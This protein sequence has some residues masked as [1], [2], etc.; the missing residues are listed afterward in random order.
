MKHLS[1]FVKVGARRLKVSKGE[2]VLVFRNP[3]GQIVIFC[4]NKDT[5]D[6]NLV[7]SCQGSVINLKLA[8]KTFNTILI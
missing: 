5:K 1:H 2:N 3:D 6:Q 4:V 7:L 8:P